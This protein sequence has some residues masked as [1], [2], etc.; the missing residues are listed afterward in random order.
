MNDAFTFGL[1]MVDIVLVFIGGTAAR[2]TLTRVKSLAPQSYRCLQYV[3][4]RSACGCL[5]G[6]SIQ[7]PAIFQDMASSFSMVIVRVAWRGIFKFVYIFVSA[8]HSVHHS[9]TNADHDIDP[10]VRAT[11][12][13][14]CDVRP[15]VACFRPLAGAEA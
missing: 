9:I 10:S 14:D 13:H 6:D 15:A 1:I 11:I 5:R 3:Y 12:L 4:T 7:T 2:S 8:D